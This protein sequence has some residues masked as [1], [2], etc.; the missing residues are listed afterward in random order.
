[1]RNPYCPNDP[2]NIE[3]RR[4]RNVLHEIADSTPHTIMDVDKNPEL[5]NW[6]CDT[7]RKAKL[8]AYPNNSKA[9]SS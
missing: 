5:V 2:Q 4:L 7:T 9:E 6:I 3:I 8:G 1:M